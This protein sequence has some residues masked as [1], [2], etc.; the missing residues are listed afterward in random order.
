MSV[1]EAL[2]GA[3]STQVTVDSGADKFHEF[4]KA[5]LLIE[6]PL[7]LHYA[8]SHRHNI[9]VCRLPASHMKPIVDVWEAKNPR[10]ALDVIVDRFMEVD[11]PF[12][13]DPEHPDIYKAEP[14]INNRPPTV[15]DLLEKGRLDE[16]ALNNIGGFLLSRPARRKFSKALLEMRGVDSQPTPDK[17]AE[18]TQRIATLIYNDAAREKLLEDYSYLCSLDIQALHDISSM[19]ERD[20]ALSMEVAGIRMVS[21]MEDI[22]LRSENGRL[23]ALAQGS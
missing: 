22:I 13:P 3:A 16:K 2:D 10:D 7:T 17:V 23:S 4:F 19:P 1:R 8:N 6:P 12:L 21:F 14:L 15:Q 5:L 18:I 11:V 20:A 9:G